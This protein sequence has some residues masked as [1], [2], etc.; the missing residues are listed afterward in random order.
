MIEGKPSCWTHRTRYARCPQVQNLPRRG[1]P[2]HH[3]AAPPANL[4]IPRF[5]GAMARFA[6]LRLKPGATANASHSRQSPLRTL[7]WSRLSSS[8]RTQ[9]D[10]A[11][12]PPCSRVPALCNQCMFKDIREPGSWILEDGQPHGA[13]VLAMW[14]HAHVVRTTCTVR[15]FE[16]NCAETT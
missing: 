10:F 16:W 6:A 2:A 3:M 11:S 5:S 1:R 7:R 15:G 9:T 14:R 8:K 13:S 12:K 4:A